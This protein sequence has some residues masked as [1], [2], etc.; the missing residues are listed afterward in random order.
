MIGKN[1]DPR[2]SCEPR[3]EVVVFTKEQKEI[4]IHEALASLDRITQNCRSGWKAF[5]STRLLRAS[6]G[7]HHLYIIKNNFDPRGSC[8][9][10]RRCDRNKSSHKRFRSTRLLRAST[11]IICLPCFSCLFRS[12]RLLRAS[13]ICRASYSRPGSDFD[14]RGSCEPRPRAVVIRSLGPGISI[15]EALASLDR[16]WRISSGRK[17]EFR[18][19]RLLRASTERKAGLIDN[20]AISIHEALASLDMSRPQSPQVPGNFDPRGSC[21]PRLTASSWSAILPISI[22]EALASL[23]VIS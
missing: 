5:R 23:D 12:T 1:F 8:E 9:P 15:H 20:L 4:S 17:A 3:H 10:R 2:G 18:S 7:L 19:T 21:E 6:T 14:P 16:R 11:L 13:T 22:H